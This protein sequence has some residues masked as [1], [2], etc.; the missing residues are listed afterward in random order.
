MRSR[1]EIERQSVLGVRSRFERMSGRLDS[2]RYSRFERVTDYDREFDDASGVLKKAYREL[3]ALDKEMS[4][5]FQRY[6]KLLKKARTPE[7]QQEV[8]DELEEYQMSLDLQ[9]TVNRYWN[10][11]DN[12]MNAYE[13]LRNNLGADKKQGKFYTDYGHNYRGTLESIVKL[14]NNGYASIT[15]VGR[16]KA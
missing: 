6:V 16:I 11:Y 1:Y 12:F 2:G 8:I 4:K 7:E 13:D 5:Y 10:I 3:V 9:R 14:N 15:E